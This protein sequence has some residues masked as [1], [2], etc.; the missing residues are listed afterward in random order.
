MPWRK[1]FKRLTASA[2]SFLVTACWLALWWV[3]PRLVSSDAS[4]IVAAKVQVLPPSQSVSSVH[5]SPKVF[6][7]PSP[8]GFSTVAREKREL[9]LLSHHA[10]LPAHMLPRL[11]GADGLVMGSRDRRWQAPVPSYTPELALVDRERVSTIDVCEVHVSQ[12]AGLRDASFVLPAVPAE[13]AAQT[14]ATWEVTARVNIGV[15]GRVR[16]VFLEWPGERTEIA[17]W[18]EQYLVM[19]RAK[20]AVTVRSGR[21]TI[22]CSSP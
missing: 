21:V 1:A 14:N 15:D 20:P 10:A 13:L 9:K 5:R 4:G 19:G 11:S 6:G 16:H 3:W 7:P 22:G 8:V 12:S 2:P 17:R 18:V